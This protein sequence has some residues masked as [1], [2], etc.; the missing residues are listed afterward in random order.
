MA[1][2]QDKLNSTN[3]P[4]AHDALGRVLSV[5]GEINDIARQAEIYLIRPRPAT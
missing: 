4:Q 2:V 5:K 1:R 3:K